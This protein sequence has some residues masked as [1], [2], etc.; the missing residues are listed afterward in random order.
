MLPG[1]MKEERSMGSKIR[2]AALIVLGSS[3]LVAPAIAQAPLPEFT[4]VAVSEGL[5]GDC[6]L[7]VSPDPKVLLGNPLRLKNQWSEQATIYQRDGFWQ[8]TLVVNAESSVKIVG[9]GTYLSAC[10]PGDWKAPIKVPLKAPGAPAGNSFKVT[11]AD[12]AA[13][14]TLR[15]GVQY[16][17]GQ[18]NWKA[19][20]SGTS[21]R[22]A[23]FAGAE[24]K[25]YYFRARTVKAGK[26]TD[27][28]P[29]R[30]VRT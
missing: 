11:W 17:I 18:G 10:I 29:P 5:T 19:W 2:R 12:P 26:A 21:Q 20:K 25:T 30:R 24:G 6:T 15:Y 23:T 4:S 16:R 27:W 9:A 8:K 14:A 1:S 22:S 7:L 28:S 13:P 3:S